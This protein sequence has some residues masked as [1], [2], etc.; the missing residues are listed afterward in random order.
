[1][2]N[3]INEK[4]YDKFRKKITGMEC[5]TLSIENDTEGE[6]YKISILG[7]IFS[8]KFNLSNYKVMNISFP[9]YSEHL[10]EV[11]RQFYNIF[12]IV[13]YYKNLIR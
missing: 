13:I 10:K 7:D 3:D 1:M 2:T 8:I 5:D 4:R 12:K 11:F 9:I 6:E